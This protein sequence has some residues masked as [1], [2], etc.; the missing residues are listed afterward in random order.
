MNEKRQM[1]RSLNWNWAGTL[2]D[3]VVAFLLCPYLL[4]H[5]GATHYGAWVMIGSLTGYFGLLDLGIRGSVGRYVAFY[6]ARHDPQ[7]T[8]EIVTTAFA[9]L[10]V[11]G[12][13]GLVG[14]SVATLWAGPLFGS[15]FAAA[16]L[17]P[18]RLALLLAGLNLGLQLPLNVSE[19]VLWGCQRFDQLNAVRIPF[20]IARGVLS[21]VVVFFDGGL[22][23]LS[24]L[25]LALTILGGVVKT[26]L[27]FRCEPA[28]S[29]QRGRV[30]RERMQEVFSFGIWNTV[31]SITTM[32]PTRLT[33]LLVGAL[34]GVSLVAPLSIAARLI[35][36]ASA[37]LVAA[38]GVITPIATVL[39]A[40]EQHGRQQQLLLEGGKYSLAAAT[41]ALALFLLLG[42]PLIQLWV[43]SEM[44]S[45][46]PLLVW[47]AL[48][49]WVSMSQVVTRGV[50]TAQAK[51]RALALSSLV[52]ALVTLGLGLV[53]IRTWGVLGMAVA[54]ALGDA[55]CEGLFSLVYGCR[56]LGM[57]A[58]RY[59]VRIAGA[60][61]VT[62]AAPCGLLATAVYWRPVS[63]WLDLIVYGAT[64]SVLSIAA[65]VWYNEHPRLS[66]L[67]RLNR[68]R[69][70]EVLCTP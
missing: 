26:A 68:R 56:L 51:H 70:E 2:A 49:R 53:L 11:A 30:S 48:G 19:G 25:A 5:L 6:R 42:R 67:L 66:S 69:A 37:I 52:Q 60:T 50:I 38:T 43:G 35:A 61:V 9:L 28:L 24:A 62:L 27:A 1:L 33:P 12:L 31:R 17:P 23:A 39:H 32:I 7:A 14:T 16:D 10:S 13:L 55:V 4:T 21:A 64:F 15:E 41:V 18:L 46:Y 22:V 44:A 29:R 45:A 54:I 57:S 63:S 40:R 8:G 20:D 58:T 34:L 3:S 47:M 59:A 36:T 65:V